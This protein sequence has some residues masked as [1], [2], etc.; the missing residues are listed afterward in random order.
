MGLVIYKSFP[1]GLYSSS[2]FS[3]NINPAHCFWILWVAFLSVCP[4]TPLTCGAAGPVVI[5]LFSVGIRPLK[6]RTVRGGLPIPPKTRPTTI[7]VFNRVLLTNPSSASWL[8]AIHAVPY[9]I[10]SAYSAIAITGCYPINVRLGLALSQTANGQERVT[11]TYWHFV[12]KFSIVHFF[13]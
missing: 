5:R 4:S 7:V 6:P 13:L 2:T 9:P 3:R 10:G 11:R 1:K 12:V 8:S